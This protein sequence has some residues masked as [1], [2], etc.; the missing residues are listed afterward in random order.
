LHLKGR[1]MLIFIVCLGLTASMIL[2]AEASYQASNRWMHK[3]N[4]ANA[5]LVTLLSS[6]TSIVALLLAFSFGMAEARYELRRS[7]MVAEANAISTVHLRQELLGDPARMQ[8]ADLM[9]QYVAARQML[10]QPLTDPARARLVQRTDGLQAQIWEVT[11][12]ALK[13]P[14]GTAIATPLLGA[15]NAM[16]DAAETRTAALDAH[17]PERAT[18]VLLAIVLGAA[19]LIG[20]VLA[21]L[22]ERHIVASSFL[23]LLLALAITL[24]WDL[25]SP[26]AGGIKLPNGAMDH[27]ARQ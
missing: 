14:E 23:F 12:H 11:R 15:T 9:R 13:T 2:V 5:A 24:M 19:A 10:V 6:T 26:S 4:R 27:V 1:R 25:D 21:G 18:R 8:L 16:F 3:G 7:L 17:I 22:G 20:V